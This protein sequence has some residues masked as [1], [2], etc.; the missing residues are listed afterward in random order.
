MTAF[1]SAAAMGMPRDVAAKYFTGMVQICAQ[2]FPGHPAAWGEGRTNEVPAATTLD[3][4]RGFPVH[5]PLGCPGPAMVFKSRQ[6]RTSGHPG[7]FAAQQGQMRCGDYFFAAMGGRRCGEENAP[8]TGK[9]PSP[10]RRSHT[11]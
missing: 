3:C 2:V 10:W 4:Y 6:Q 7:M 5:L 1:A 8:Y 9:R 11:W